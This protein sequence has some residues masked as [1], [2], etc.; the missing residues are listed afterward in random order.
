MRVECERVSELRANRA[1]K[2]VKGMSG[3]V[4]GR[5]NKVLGALDKVEFWAMRTAQVLLVV[6]VLACLLAPGA[7][8]H[9]EDGTPPDEA[10]S[11]LVA[12]FARL[13]KLFINV[14]YGLVLLA[15]AAGSVKAGL[16]AQVAQAFGLAGRVSMEMMSLVGG[17]VVFAVAIMTLPLANMVIDAVSENMFGSGFTVEIHNP[18]AP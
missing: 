10:A 17:V 16:G 12:I 18:F 8:A 15:F 9:A 14:M 1:A 11:N 6:A 5:Y 4:A 3:M 2:G 7:I 13:A